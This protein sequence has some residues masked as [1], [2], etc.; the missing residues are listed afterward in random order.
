MAGIETNGHTRPFGQTDRVRLPRA[1]GRP[2][3]QADAIHVGD[4]HKLAR[5]NHAI[6][7]VIGTQSNIVRTNGN[8]HGRTRGQPGRLRN[9]SQWRN[10]LVGGR[11]TGDETGLTD[12]LR[13]TSGAGR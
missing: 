13:H 8:F 1:D 4:T 7:R 6:T 10:D 9:R 3:I 2:I 5:D 12:K 11:L